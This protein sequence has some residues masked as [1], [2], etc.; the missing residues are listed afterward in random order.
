MIVEQREK[1][2][3]K[4]LKED[5]EIVFEHPENPEHGD[6]S[7]NAALVLAQQLKQNPREL[8]ENIAAKLQDKKPKFL[9]LV[10]VEGPGFINFFLK[11]EYLIKELQEV[12]KKKEKYGS[13]KEKKTIVIDYSGPNI[14]KAFGIGHLRSTIIGQAISILYALVGGKT[15]G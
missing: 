6:Y 14:A 11:Q 13:G 4:A 10:K 1:L 2:V 5:V 8:A 12:V 15:S 9:D 3:K 7:T